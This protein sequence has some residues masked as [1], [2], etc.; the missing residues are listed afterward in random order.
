M[1]D[2][3]C[4]DCSVHFKSVKQYLDAMNISYAVNPRI[5]RGLDYYTR[6]VFEF[7]SA[8][9]GAQ[10]TVCGGGRYD[11]LVEEVGGP[12]VPS[13]GFALGLERLLL[14]MKAQGI[15]LP[16]PPNCELYIACIG[17]KA[18]LKA[19]ALT[20][21]L[22]RSGVGAQFDVVGRSVK[23][24]MKYAGKIAAV[25]SM[26]LGDDD[27][28]KAE[29]NLRNMDTGE[30]QPIKLEKF[31]DDFINITVQQAADSLMDSLE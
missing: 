30:T 28:A 22:R 20:Q 17:E 11:G 1:L 15:E 24:Q 27:L 16:T 10:G 18:Y 6:T 21:Q 5:V 31:V 2:Y 13:L 29:V 3:I 7:V 23:A 25:Y 8:D 14:L 12:S 4:E 26:V 19:A 9:I